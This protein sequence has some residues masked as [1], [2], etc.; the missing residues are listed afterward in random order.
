MAT[1][2]Q[3]RLAPPAVIGIIGG[4]QLGRMSALAARAMGYRVVVLEPKVPCACTPVVEEQIEAAYD[5]PTGLEKLFSIA[6]VV[7]FEFE[8]IQK[9]PLDAFAGRKPIRPSPAILSIAQNREREKNYFSDSGFPVAPFRV[10]AD[11]GDVEKILAEDFPFPAILKTADFGYDGKGQ[12]SVQHPSDL[13]EAWRSFEGARAVLEKRIAFQAEYSVIVARNPAGEC[14]SY[15]LCRNIH[16]DHILDVTFSPA[17]LSEGQSAQAKDLCENLAV[18]LGLEGILVIELFLTREG[19]WI[20]NEVAPRPH[21]SGHFSIDG[22]ET[23]QFENHIR[24]V[25]NQPLG[26]TASLSPSAMQNLLGETLLE[27]GDDLAETVFSTER[28]HLHLYD[29]GEAKPG[30]KMGHINLAAEEGQSL[31]EKVG[32]LRKSLGLPPI[33]ED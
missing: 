26:S 1:S 33:T 10:I 32:K 3:K 31:R 20:I 30:R 18:S 9:E 15:P 14:V 23:S 11:D 16:R 2:T 8:N 22:S 19:E 27:Q 17:E 28:A 24:A 4:G 7:T 29:K 13:R 21:N 25:C 5:D 12:V 6:D